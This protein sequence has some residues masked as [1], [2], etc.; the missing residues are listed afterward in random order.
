VP[1]EINDMAKKKKN[2]PLC[3][4]TAPANTLDRK[5]NSGTLE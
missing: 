1:V 3:P 2:S 4:L 5:G